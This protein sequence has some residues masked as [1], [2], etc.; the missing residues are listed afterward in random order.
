MDMSSG[1]SIPALIEAAQQHRL[2]VEK[3]QE[4]LN[5]LYGSLGKLRD[6]VIRK[7]LGPGST[8]LVCYSAHTVLLGAQRSH[9]VCH[10]WASLCDMH[11][12]V[13]GCQRC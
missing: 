8:L 10:A 5:A 3:V 6:E 12:A 4:S 1:S 9:T 7:V 13:H 2:L 11:A